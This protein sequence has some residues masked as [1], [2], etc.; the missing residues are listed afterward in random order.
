MLL[1]RPLR[2]RAFSP[3]PARSSQLRE[4][5]RAA[6]SR[7]TSALERF[8][9]APRLSKSDHLDVGAPLANAWEAIRQLDAARSPLVRALFAMRALPK[10]LRHRA[11]AP[12]ALRVDAIAAS[13]HGFRLLEER[14][15]RSLTI[16][17]I[18]KLWQPQIE[19]RDVPPER[20]APFCEPGFVKLAWELRA[21]EPMVPMR[22]FRRR[23]FSA[24]N[25]TSVF[26]SF[27]M[28]GSI[29]LLAQFFQLVQGYTPLQAGLRT[30]PWWDP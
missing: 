16:G 9:P 10:R 21:A 8:I 27:G 20:F 14:A 11:P 6:T 12:P 22:F 24:A 15:G 2:L 26:M 19:F 29:F 25:L 3:E 28:F 18:G 23:A 30:L 13:T 4:Q 17:A 7:G 1:T 5:I